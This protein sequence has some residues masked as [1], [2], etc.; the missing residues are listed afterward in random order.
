MNIK[1]V[2]II[3]IIELAITGCSHRGLFD[4][5][6]ISGSYYHDAVQNY[7]ESEHYE[8]K[9]HDANYYD[10]YFGPYGVIGFHNQFA[11]P[12]E[13]YKKGNLSG[14]EIVALWHVTLENGQREFYYVRSL[15][16]QGVVA[17]NRYF[18]SDWS[19]YAYL[20]FGPMY[21]G[22]EGLSE[23]QKP[24][25][26]HIRTAPSGYKYY[27]W[28]KRNTLY[29]RVLKKKLRPKSTPLNWI[30]VPGI[31]ISQQQYDALSARC[32]K[33][34]WR[35]RCFMDEKF[36]GVTPEQ[37]TYIKARH[38]PD[39]EDRLSGKVEKPKPS[40]PNPWL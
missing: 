37:L 21:L 31:K 8:L 22:Q 5:N 33:P 4:F 13:F 9:Y 30:E 38:H 1:K 19:Y 27:S 6:V 10:S 34:W 26:R 3:V 16:N 2:L 24:D 25:A 39:D 20:S 40:P 17:D 15:P 29:Y 35:V 32:N 36:I 7:Y 12:M 18:W 11:G 14:E 23:L 28:G